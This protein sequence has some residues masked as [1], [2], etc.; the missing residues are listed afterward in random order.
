M[1]APQIST[2]AK[3]H[4]KPFVKWAGGKRALLEILCASLPQNFNAYF[5]P[6]LGGGALFFE[7]AN[8]GLLQGK[9]AYLNDKNAELINAYLAIQKEPQKLLN[10]LNLMQKAHSKEHFYS[11]RALDRE[12]NFSTLSPIFRAARFI[13]LNKTCFNG[14]CRYNAKGQFNTPF[15]AYKNPKIYDEMLILNAHYALQDAIILNEDFE[16]VRDLAK[17]SDFV[18]FD[19]PYFPLNSTSN[20]TSYTQNFLESDQM[21]LYALFCDL[22]SRGVKL[23]QSNSNTDFIKNLYKNFQ[24]QA[25]QAKRAINCKGDKRG[26]VSEF[27]IRGDDG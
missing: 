3:H 21:R 2:N 9:K 18:Y 14:L 10:E 15:G 13:Y 27:V 6:F 12:V 25:I 4:A 7:L 23:L 8:K 19:P 20:F 17:K 16:F 11:I 22:N 1:S 26:A 5:E 24:I